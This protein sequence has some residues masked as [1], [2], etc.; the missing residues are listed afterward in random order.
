MCWLT[1]HV[2]CDANVFLEQPPR[3]PRT[4]NGLYLCSKLKLSLDGLCSP[5][6][7]RGMASCLDSESAEQVGHYV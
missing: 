7:P 5:G 6:W 2:L 3:R 1:T 4:S